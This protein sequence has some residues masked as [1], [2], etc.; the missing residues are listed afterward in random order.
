MILKV[1]EA[2]EYPQGSYPVERVRKIV[3]SY[4]PQNF[5]EACAVV[6]HFDNFLAEREEIELAHGWVKSLSMNERGEV[7]AD[8]PN[9]TISKK[10]AG[11]IVTKQL[12]YISAEIFAFDEVDPKQ[13]PYLGR[14]AFL[15]RS[16]PQIPTTKIP[17]AFG[18]ALSLFG[19][20]QKKETENNRFTWTGK[21]EKDAVEELKKFYGEDLLTSKTN[22][23]EDKNGGRTRESGL[24]TDNPS[25]NF[26][27]GDEMD[28]KEAQ[29]LRDENKRLQDENSNLQTKVNEFESKE[30]D[31]HD[32]DTSAKLEKFRDEGKILP[33]KFDS[34][35]EKVLKMSPEAQDLYFSTLEDSAAVVELDEDHFA[36]KNKASESGATGITDTIRAFAK[37]HNLS[38]EAAWDQLKKEKPELFEEV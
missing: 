3:D 14:V 12:R 33:A 21:I 4:D 27:Q 10:L 35:K 9:E 23:K 25:A 2:G 37:E 20:T 5:I 36:S 19:F 1:F 18:R 8:I 11:W 13:S 26:N 38:Y 32:K 24:Q 17:S 15:G 7:Y 34:I 6:G 31:E 28:E 16:I 29:A 22:F 30:R